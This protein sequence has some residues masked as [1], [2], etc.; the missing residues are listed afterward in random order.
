MPLQEAL[1]REFPNSAPRAEGGHLKD[2][3]RSVLQVVL[4]SDF[5]PRSKSE[6]TRQQIEGRLNLTRSLANELADLPSYEVLALHL[7]Y[8]LKERGIS[9]KTFFRDVAT[10]EELDAATMMGFRRVEQPV[11]DSNP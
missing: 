6:E 9:Q 4:R 1:E 8:P 2:S 5:D 3:G 11:P 10:W 7:Y